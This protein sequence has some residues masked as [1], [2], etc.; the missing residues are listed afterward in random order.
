M[1]ISA[2]N[3]AY[4][5][6]EVVRG[7]RGMV[8]VVIADDEDRVCRLIKSLLDFDELKLELAGMAANGLEALALVEKHK[9]DILITDIRMPGCNGLELI[10]KVRKHCPDIAIIIISGYAEFEYAKKA[11]Q[12]GVSEYLLK[13]INKKELND[14]LKKICLTIREERET[15]E[16]IQAYEKKHKEGIKKI[17]DALIL[18]LLDKQ[19]VSLTKEQLINQYHLNILPGYYQAFCLK[20]NYGRN[21]QQECSKELVWER[22]VKVFETGMKKHCAAWILCQKNCYLYGIVNYITKEK[23]DVKKMLRDCLNQMDAQK[24]ILGNIEFTLG[25]GCVEK[26]PQYLARTMGSAVLGCEEHY[27]EGTGKLM[28]ELE[29]IPVLCGQKLLDKY[30]RKTGHALEVYSESEAVGAV[31]ELQAAVDMVQQ[32]HGWEVLEL[33]RAACT[34]FIARL[35]IRDKERVLAWFEHE[36]ENCVN[37]EE[38]FTVLKELVAEQMSTFISSREEDAA[39]PIRLAKCYIRNHYSEQITLEEVSREVGLSAAYFSV[40]FKKETEVGF[41]KY[42]M[43]VRMEQAKVLLRETNLSVAEICRKV[44]YNDNKHFGHTF[45]KANGVKPALYRK[46]YG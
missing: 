39:R 14:T 32:V 13:P 2:A 10:E 9:P 3:G 24:G 23:D 22:A 33:V 36:C 25:L 44:G 35:D 20:A 18:Q 5:E 16:N 40:L 26:E 12:Y 8:K 38:L 43:N 27:V 29:R 4:K 37:K 45:E 7:I 34:M 42:L 15:Q 17:Q 31:E 41:A 21:G 28:E 11:M 1:K 30:A 19:S 46:L 6:T